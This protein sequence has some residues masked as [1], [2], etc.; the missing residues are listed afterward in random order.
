MSKNVV[1]SNSVGLFS[2]P[3]PSTGY[4]FINLG[5]ALSNTGTYN[6]LQC[7]NRVQSIS[8]NIE[9][10]DSNVIQLGQS[11]SQDRYL[12][13]YPTVNLQFE[14]LING[15]GNENKLGFMTNYHNDKT[16]S[17][18][19]TSSPFLLNG[20]VSRSNAPADSDFL[21][22]LD[23]RDERNLFVAVA[24][25]GRDLH[26]LAWGQVYDDPRSIHVIGFGNS[27]LTNYS[28]S[29]AVGQ[30]P[31]AR[32][33]YLCHN[34]TVYNSGVNQPIPALDKRTAKP[35]SGI[36][37][38]IPPTFNDD[39]YPSVL[40]PSDMQISITSSAAQNF[41]SLK[42]T[43]I[44]LQQNLLKNSEN[45]RD[46]W[47]IIGGTRYDL[48][49]VDPFGNYRDIPY[50]VL[51]S[52]GYTYQVANYKP[53]SNE[54]MVFS[55]W[56]K[57]GGYNPT[58]IELRI[59][60]DGIPQGNQRSYPISST[61]WTRIIHTGAMDSNSSVSC[62]VRIDNP[63]SSLEDYQI[64][65]VQLYSSG[66]SNE[67]LG[68]TS[69]PIEQYS[70]SFSPRDTIFDFTDFKLQSFDFDLSLNRQPIRSISY[71]LPLDYKVLEPTRLQTNISFIVGDNITGNLSRL[72]QENNN[73]NFR[74]KIR[75]PPGLPQKYVPGT[76]PYYIENSGFALDYDFRNCK[77]KSLNYSQEINN[78]IL[79]NATFETELSS[80]N[81]QRGLFVSGLLNYSTTLISYGY[82]TQEDGFYILQEDG[83]KII[84]NQELQPLF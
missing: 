79:G 49:G 58:G 81:F 74:I 28:C 35:I 13:P 76:I 69:E 51:A 17:A 1:I 52:I 61:D 42:N 38:S 5:G 24:P 12:L 25:E 11:S 23:Y 50:C 27:Y 18:N 15:V 73:Y 48:S 8:F 32:L 45:F 39:G 26:K 37:Y 3:A 59:D 62:A 34:I 14:Y 83:S 20:F 63:V 2:G 68:T 53:L 36:F 77:L 41:S 46:S 10:P 33:N 78:K 60:R 7:I 22:P 54:I 55:C 80:K 75:Q 40:K 66:Y 72:L 56:A 16:Q 57:A 19:F 71:K 64:F 67:Y 84:I 21:W 47:V 31:S 44:L 6:L 30:L 70:G 65:G 43:G 29:F 9:T 82:L 4:H